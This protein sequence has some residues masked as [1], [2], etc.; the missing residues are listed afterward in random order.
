MSYS[1]ER[2]Y[3]RRQPPPLA[4]LADWRRHHE[5][6]HPIPEIVALLQSGR[7][8]DRWLRELASWPWMAGHWNLYMGGAGHTIIGGTL[9][10]R[11]LLHEAAADILKMARHYG[12]FS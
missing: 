8:R 9:T 12:D 2:P 3:P 4:Q 6:P 10:A 5:V 11:Q 7:S 1:W